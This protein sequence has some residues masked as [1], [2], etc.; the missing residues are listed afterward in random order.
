MA[1]IVG[2]VAGVICA[3]LAIFCFWFGAPG[4]TYAG[5]FDRSD[6]SP[7]QNGP[8]VTAQPLPTA[9]DYS[10]PYP[11]AADPAGTSAAAPIGRAVW[12]GRGGRRLV[13]LLRGKSTAARLS[14][15]VIHA[16]RAQPIRRQP[17]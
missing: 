1:M 2:G 17:T 10:V 12:R 11:E 13:G 5:Q 6:R 7:D 15:S 8:R 3:S 14:A 9:N 16:L 4:E